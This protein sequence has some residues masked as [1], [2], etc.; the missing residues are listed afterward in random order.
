MSA[1]SARKYSWDDFKYS[2]RMCLHFAEY[3]KKWASSFNASMKFRRSGTLRQLATMTRLRAWLR[4]CV[5]YYEFGE[6]LY[7]RADTPDTC[8][9]IV[10]APSKPFLTKLAMFNPQ[11]FT[12]PTIA[13][14]IVSASVVGTEQ[15]QI[16][17]LPVALC[18]PVMHTYAHLLCCWDICCLID[19]HTPKH[20]GIAFINNGLSNQV[21]IACDELINFR[22][23]TS[24]LHFLVR[25][26]G[27][28]ST[29]HYTCSR[30]QP[31]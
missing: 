24:T 12:K 19:H 28:I 4:Q 10:D 31:G 29:R 1:Q 3:L 20:W 7:S 8:P 17:K 9:L 18:S 23:M 11:P 27:E 5:K 26:V 22:C 21:T 13:N 14:V 16:H 25:Y 6:M 2:C 15:N 30:N